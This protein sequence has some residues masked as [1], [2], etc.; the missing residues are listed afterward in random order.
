MSVAFYFDTIS[1]VWK[2]SKNCHIPSTLLHQL[3]P[4]PFAL[5]LIVYREQD[6]YSLNYSGL[7]ADIMLLYL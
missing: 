5:I 3:L 1:N 4:L 2:S 6:N 7:A